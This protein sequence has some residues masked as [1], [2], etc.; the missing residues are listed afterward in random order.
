MPAVHMRA[1]EG[2][3]TLAKEAMA[4]RAPCSSRYVIFLFFDLSIRLHATPLHAQRGRG[5]R[6]WSSEK[7]DQFKAWAA[8][9]GFGGVSLVY[10]M[11]KGMSCAAVHKCAVGKPPTK[12]G[13]SPDLNI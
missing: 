2:E 9:A 1:Q 7:K 4:T 12:P 11:T 8:A 6:A 13:S 10:W 5:F 3:D